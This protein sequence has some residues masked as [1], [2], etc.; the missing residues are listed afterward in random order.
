[1][2]IES[3]RT[4]CM[5]KKGVEEGLPFDE[6]VLVF[7]VAGKIF[8]L[9][10]INDFEYVNLKCEPERSIELRES[11]E[12]IKPGYHM[13]KKHWNSVYIGADVNERML[14]ELTDDSYNLVYSKLPAKV[15][16]ELEEDKGA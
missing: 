4:Y 8:A 12:G 11:Y 14:M 5:S 15:R 3:Y 16:K 13:N 2:D 7:K 10:D 1:M 6:N 9:T